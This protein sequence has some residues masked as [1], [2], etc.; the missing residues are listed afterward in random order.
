MNSLFY[1]LLLL[2]IV[3]CASTMPGRDIDTGSKNVLATFSANDVFTNEQVQ[4]IQFSIKNNTKDWIEFEGATFEGAPGT[5]VLVGDR[6]SSW[7]EACLLEKEV[8]DYNTSVVLG[9]LAV[10]GAVIATSSSHQGT[11]TTGAVIAL[12]SI[13]AA[14]VKDLQS[15]KNK[16][17]FQKAFPSKHIFRA[18]VI[19]PGKV[20]QRWIIVENP[21][22][23]EFTVNSK[24]KSGDEIKLKIARRSIMPA[25]I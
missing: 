25:A 12:G 15:S 16:V 18:F 3:S 13:G 17:E 10:A 23:V 9:S 1:T 7:I 6:L 22:G 11:A 2:L 21:N 14:A 24:S 4:M 5:S 19:P 20:I 8:S